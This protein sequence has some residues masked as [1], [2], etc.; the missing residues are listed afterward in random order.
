MGTTSAT[1]P[2]PGAHKD[3]YEESIAGNVPP[4]RTGVGFAVQRLEKRG[5]G[6]CGR[7]NHMRRLH[8]KPVRQPGQPEA[9][10]L[11]RQRKEEL[12][13]NGR[14]QRVESRGLLR[15]D[16]VGGPRRAEGEV[17]HDGDDGVLLDVEVVVRV[18]HDVSPEEAHFHDGQEMSYG[19]A[20]G[21]RD[22]LGHQR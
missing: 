3:V 21:E 12:I 8:D 9:K 5:V 6:K 10:E 4:I 7:P 16:D 17:G 2:N 18:E 19:A 20:D 22:E 15:L 14:V 11:H 1:H 13:A